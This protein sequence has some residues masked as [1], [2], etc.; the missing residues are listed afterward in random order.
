LP[1]CPLYP[2]KKRT[3]TGEF[4]PLRDTRHFAPSDRK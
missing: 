1:A 4:E 3:S 2:E